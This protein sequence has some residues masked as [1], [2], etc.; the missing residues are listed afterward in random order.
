[1]KRK[2]RREN[3]RRNDFWKGGLRQLSK[4]LSIYFSI[5]HIRTSH[6]SQW[7]KGKI[8]LVV[9]AVSDMTNYH[10][11]ISVCVYNKV[12]K[13]KMAYHHQHRSRIS[14]QNDWEK[15]RKKWVK[16]RIQWFTTSKVSKNSLSLFHLLSFFLFPISFL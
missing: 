9:F 11:Y 3:E 5:T 13:K 6:E 4:S 10:Y 8:Y 7:K 1:M 14:S 16:M 2:E 12:E 15:G